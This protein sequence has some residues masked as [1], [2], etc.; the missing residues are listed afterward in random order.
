MQTRLARGKCAGLLADHRSAHVVYAF[1][2]LF[3]SISLSFFSPLLPLSLL[4]P[5]LF[6]LSLCLFSFP[7]SSLSSSFFLP[8]SPFFPLGS[9]TPAREEEAVGIV[10][11]AW[12]GGHCAAP[13]YADQRFATLANGWLSWRPSIRSYAFMFVYER[14]TSALHTASR[15]LPAHAAGA[16]NRGDGA[17]TP[18]PGL[19]EFEFIVDRRSRSTSPTQAPVA[20]LL[21]TS[22]GQRFEK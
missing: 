1:F 5:L 2:F 19:D 16:Q 10:S 21:S 6:L 15:G 13:V 12:M 11:G 3:F 9:P 4:P 17:F 8:S 7:C 20:L 14:G 22:D 18:R